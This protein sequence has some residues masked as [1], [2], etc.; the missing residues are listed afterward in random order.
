MYQVNTH[1]FL[2]T[3]SKSVWVNGCKLRIKIIYQENIIEPKAI[4]EM[5]NYGMKML[6]WKLETN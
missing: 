2:E 1:N 6:N 5:G 4:A 3:K